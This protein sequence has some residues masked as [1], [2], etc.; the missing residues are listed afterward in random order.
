MYPSPQTLNVARILVLNM[1]SEADWNSSLFCHQA[2]HEYEEGRR[3]GIDLPPSC[4]VPV[5]RR[6]E[7]PETLRQSR[8]WRDVATYIYCQLDI[9]ENLILIAGFSGCFMQLDS[10]SSPVSKSDF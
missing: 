2:G 10:L 9:S 3:V 5:P 1:T 7:V 8:S 4:L 6:L